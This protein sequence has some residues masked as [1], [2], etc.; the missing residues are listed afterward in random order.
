MNDE[1]TKRE[2]KSEEKGDRASRE[3]LT[4]MYTES[5]LWER[6]VLTVLH[7][8]CVVKYKYIYIFTHTSGKTAQFF[9][10]I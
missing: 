4:F 3:L 1:Q 5:L 8:V 7:A 9:A 6:I 2:E 10:N